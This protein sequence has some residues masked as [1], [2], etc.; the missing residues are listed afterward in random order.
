[1]K[2]ILSIILVVAMCISILPA[3]STSA[4]ETSTTSYVYDFCRTASESTT[5]IEQLNTYDAK[6]DTY[7]ITGRNWHYLSQSSG[8]WTSIKYWTQ[9]FISAATEAGAWFAIVIRVP[10]SGTY[11]VNIG[12]SI[13]SGY[14]TGNVYILPKENATEADY[15]S[16]DNIYAQ[17]NYTTS[18]HANILSEK[19]LLA[20]SDNQEFIV[21]FKTTTE[22]ATT[23]VPKNITLERVSSVEEF[24][25]AI[26][27]SDGSSLA[28]SAVDTYEETGRNW[29]YLDT[30]KALKT[31]DDN[32]NE[33][34]IRFRGNGILIQP[35]RYDSIKIPNTWLAV[36]IKVSKPGI[37]S[38]G[39]NYYGENTGNYDTGSMY[40]LSKDSDTS[41]YLSEAYKAADINYTTEKN[42]QYDL[43]PDSLLYVGEANAEFDVVFSATTGIAICPTKLTLTEVSDDVTLGISADSNLQVGK[44]SVVSV[45]A[46]DKK[47]LGA[48][49]TS[50]QSGVAAI[51]DGVIT[52]I[53]E[54]DTVIKANAGEYSAS[55]PLTVTHP[56]A[57][58]E[59]AT[60]AKI[61]ITAPAG[62]TLTDVSGTIQDS[63][64]DRAIN[65]PISATAPEVPGLE[66]KYWKNLSSGSVFSVEETISFNLASNTSIMAVYA[67]KADGYLVEFANANRAIISSEYLASGST[68][69]A[70]ALPSLTGYG[71]ASSWSDYPEVVGS[72]DIQSVA[73]YDAPKAITLTV[74]NGLADKDSYNYN[75][76]V[77]VTAANAPDGK[78]F[79]HWTRGTQIVS[80]DSEYSFYAWSNATLTANYADAAPEFYPTVILD[81]NARNDGEADAYMM[82]LVG[83]EG[84]T[85]LERGI[86]FGGSGL[87]L[88]SGTVYKA[89]SV[90]GAAQFSAMM[91]DTSFTI[92]AV[93][94][95]VV[96]ND[97]G[98]I[99]I[100]YSAEK[101]M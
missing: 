46:N 83:F 7:D 72:S 48:T 42:G 9:G 65:T 59:D 28:K 81:D 66:F 2:R 68:I 49:L 75:D 27:G 12:S 58:I 91:P 61:Y 23:I 17:I 53:S 52:A 47:L 55:A 62:V 41:A 29:H 64:L 22:G 31:K 18:S 32:N 5:L 85:I 24:N 44:K 45:T 10:E 36:R 80:Y 50:T 56:N 87:T 34:A 16:T 57:K 63:Q 100:A 33:G 94:A 54:G 43:D 71:T 25:F 38:V 84:K 69:V 13:Y 67:K 60:T 14:R 89:T 40:I 39:F 1:M 6:S 98:T 90:L 76:K 82:E 70:P 35:S 19:T 99:R 97:N 101:V 26:T 51:E 78:V 74:V 92:S 86:L 20:E 11:S 4:A 96:Y 3:V 93:R 21:V 73:I 95:Y 37:Y 88:T 79:S 30:E 15:T 8:N 77:T